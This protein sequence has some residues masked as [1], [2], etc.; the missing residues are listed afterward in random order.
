MAAPRKYRRSCGSR[1]RGWRLRPGPRQPGGVQG[2]RADGGCFVR[3]FGHQ[4]R[5]P[6]FRGTHVAKQ[7]YGLLAK[8][9][10]AGLVGPAVRRSG[11]KGKWPIQSWMCDQGGAALP[12]DPEASSTPVPRSYPW[13]RSPA[14]GHALSVAACGKSPADGQFFP[15][16]PLFSPEVRPCDQPG[17]FPFPGRRTSAER[18]LFVGF[19]RCCSATPYTGSRQVPAASLSVR[20]HT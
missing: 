11:P 1:R 7:V 20:W 10:Q 18:S 13:R 15:A 14:D 16:D 3:V 19:L 12:A 17:P 8:V 6:G 9:L 2:E 5:G 4:R